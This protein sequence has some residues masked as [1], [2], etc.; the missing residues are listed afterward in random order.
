M[1]LYIC[2]SIYTYIYIYISAY[3]YIYIYLF[4]S[5]L[6]YT[7][8]ILFVLSLNCLRGFSGVYDSRAR[9][10]RYKVETIHK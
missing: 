8:L 10:N 6:I 9:T 5:L 4:I 2:T 3:I 7:A 1:F